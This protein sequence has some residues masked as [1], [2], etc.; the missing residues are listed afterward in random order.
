MW[1]TLKSHLHGDVCGR[2]SRFRLEWWTCWIQKG[3]YQNLAKGKGVT[4]LLS[5][6]FVFGVADRDLERARE[7]VVS[8]ELQ[9]VRIS[10]TE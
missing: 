10:L 8:F 3:Y 7:V 1:L 2:D 9:G 4:D 5:L 6:G